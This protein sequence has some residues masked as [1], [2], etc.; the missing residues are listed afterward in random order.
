MRRGRLGRHGFEAGVKR[1][2]LN[3]YEMIES[4]REK[5][6]TL[7]QRCFQS[8]DPRVTAVYLSS[9]RVDR[10]ILPTAY[11]AYWLQGSVSSAGSPSPFHNAEI[12]YK[13]FQAVP[14]NSS[15]DIIQFAL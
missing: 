13:P 12:L 3:A 2:C 6:K 14:F 10:K 7:L 5:I 15:S 1:V 8:R 9:L 11:S 4:A